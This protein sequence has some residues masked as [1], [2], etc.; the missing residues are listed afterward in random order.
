MENIFNPSRLSFARQRAKLTKKEL[1]SQSEL[2]FKTIAN[3]E[4]GTRVPSESTIE[5][6]SVALGFP[7]EFFFGHDLEAPGASNASFRSFSR[8]TSTQRDSAL[9]AGGIA[10]TFSEWI[11]ERFNLPVVNVPDLTGQDPEV[12]A[13][14]VRKEWNQGLMPIKNMVHLLESRGIRVFSLV[15]DSK[16]VNAFS[17]WSRGKI[18]FV[19]LNTVKSSE[20]SRFD[21]AHELGHL[22][23]HRHGDPK[24][25]EVEAEANQFASAFLM[26]RTEMKGYA[27]RCQSVNDILVLKK[28]WNVSAMALVYRLHKVGVLTE[29]VYRAMCIELSSKGMR[30]SEPDS[31]NRETSQILKKVFLALKEKGQGIKD[32]ARDLRLPQ[33]ELHKLIFGLTAVSLGSDNTS[34][35]KSLA[36]KGHLTLVSSTVNKGDVRMAKNPPKG[37]GH[38]VGA[39]KDRT[40]TQTP[41]GHYVKRN[42]DDGRFMDVKADKT[43]FKGVTKEKK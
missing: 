19:F 27:L 21:A 28:R 10:F 6:M 15:E 1:A 40:Q 22:V 8:M 31:S 39:V 20:S 2:V 33:E 26:P 5:K 16:E 25:K 36:R 43:P 18:P 23:L 42:S 4:E 37:D 17:S 30:V 24:G 41:S 29:W 32:I 3:Y 14:I 12:A 11:E 35:V 13:E 9:A 38:R 34:P 7:K